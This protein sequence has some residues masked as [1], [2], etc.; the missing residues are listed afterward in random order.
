M[1]VSSLGRISLED[2][3]LDLYFEDIPSTIFQRKIRI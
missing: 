3:D 2:I 1:K